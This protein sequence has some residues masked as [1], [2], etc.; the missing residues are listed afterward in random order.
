[1]HQVSEGRVAEHTGARTRRSSRVATLAAL[2][3]GAVLALA[4]CSSSHAG[5]PSSTAAGG[6]SPAGGASTAGVGTSTGQGSDSALAAGYAG[7]F[8][9]PTQTGPKAVTG[10]NVWVISCGQL[11][12]LCAQEAAST[13]E[14]AQVLGWHAT[15]QDGK[16]DAS[17]ASATINQA[18]AAKV[19]GIIIYGFDC[20]GIKTALSNAKAAHVPVVSAEGV[21]CNDP[22]YHSGPAMY[23]ASV[24]MMGSTSGASHPQ[25]MGEMSAR[26]LAAKLGGSGT[27]IYLNETSYAVSQYQNQ[28]FSAEMTKDC[29]KCTVVNVPWTFAQVGTSASQA[30]SAAFLQHPDAKAVAFPYDAMM[31]LGLETDLKQAHFTGIVVGTQGVNMG[32]VRSGVETEDTAAP[33]SLLGWGAAD[34]LNRLFAGE[35]PDSLPNEGGGVIDVDQAHNLPATGDVYSTFPFDFK[36]IYTKMWT[37]N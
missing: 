22:L 20:P 30:W 9:K 36:A 28:G 31:T 15:L 17:V 8:Q 27:V 14:A 3:G 11:Y 13:T 24:N 5:S 34:T 19:D 16:A 6:T 26:Y 10:K 12:P 23:T 21:D 29:P 7:D 33:N 35:S 4:A 25:V 2:V 18:I 32:L 1:M 37:G